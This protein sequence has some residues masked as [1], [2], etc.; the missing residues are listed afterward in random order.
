MV[1]IEGVFA[2]CGAALAPVVSRW[3]PHELGLK[4]VANV[5]VTLFVV[6]AMAVSQREEGD[7]ALA[8][9]EADEEVKTKK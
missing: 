8:D 7:E 3:V 6:G 1:S 9:S 4:A 2:R 5:V